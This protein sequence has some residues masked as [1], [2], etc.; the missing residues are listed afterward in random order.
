M[1]SK[2]S[3]LLIL[4]LLCCYN[5]WPI[6]N[7]QT[8]LI[9]VPEQSNIFFHTVNTKD[10]Y[11]DTSKYMW[12]YTYIFILTSAIPLISETPTCLWKVCLILLSRSLALWDSWSSRLTS[13]L[14]EFCT[15]RNKREKKLTAIQTSTKDSFNIWCVCIHTELPGV[16]E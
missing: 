6:Y 8:S 14:S 2:M 3:P 4:A 5:R 16:V 12:K 13:L 15:Y 10:F 7:I 1:S 11:S 9:E